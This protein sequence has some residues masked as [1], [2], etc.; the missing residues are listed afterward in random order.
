MENE[1]MEDIYYTLIGVMQ[2]EFCVPGVENL[3][4]EGGEC[5]RLYAQVME[6]YEHLRRRL[7]VEDEDADVE[8]IV[9]SMMSIERIVAMKMFECGMKFSNK[10]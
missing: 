3:F 5:E 7:G 9:N 10:E 4:A 6:A 2:E 8:T 1:R